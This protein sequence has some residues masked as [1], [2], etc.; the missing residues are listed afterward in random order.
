MLRRGGR[1]DR[2]CG[3]PFLRRRSL[4]L[5]PFPVVRVKLRFQTITMIMCLSG[6]NRSSLH[7][8]AVPYGVVGCCE[9][10]EHSSGL[11]FS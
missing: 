5:W 11:L 3:T 2:S 6:S 1:Q 10:D 9:V 8:A 4:L 7:E